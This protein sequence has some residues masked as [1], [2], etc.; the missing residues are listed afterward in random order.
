MNKDMFDKAKCKYCG[1]T[2]KDCRQCI[3]KIG[4]PCYWLNIDGKKSVCSACEDKMNAEI[5]KRGR[6]R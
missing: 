4:R 3:K 5:K 6:S 1:C 2:Q